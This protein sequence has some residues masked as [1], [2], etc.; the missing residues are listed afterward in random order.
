M[1]L[2]VGLNRRESPDG[3]CISDLLEI[4]TELSD[5]TGK[6]GEFRWECVLV[7]GERFL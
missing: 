2:E 5:D 6:K 4:L 1:S 3:Q 7:L